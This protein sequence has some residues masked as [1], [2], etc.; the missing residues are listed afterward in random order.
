LNPSAP[1]LRQLRR[2]NLAWPAVLVPVPR[3]LWPFDPYVV[4]EGASVR[5]NVWR[6][7][8]YLVQHFDERDNERLSINRTEWDERQ[9]QFREDITWDDLQRLK[10]EAG[11]GDRAAVELFPPDRAIVNVANMRHLWLLR[12]PPNGRVD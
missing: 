8:T 10:A 9:K 7:R 5:L 4:R 1:Q 11:F 12:A 6:S 2:D 3:E